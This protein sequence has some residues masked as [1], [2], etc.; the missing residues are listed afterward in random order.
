M[1]WDLEEIS[2]DYCKL[3]E[4]MSPEDKMLWTSLTKKNEEYK[5]QIKGLNKAITALQKTLALMKDEKRL[6]DAK[7]VV[8]NHT[9]LELEK[10]TRC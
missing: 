3:K 10:K 9:L 6:E 2:E 7:E 1:Q 8:K 5:K 4:Q